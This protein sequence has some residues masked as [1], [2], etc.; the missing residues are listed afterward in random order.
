MNVKNISI[1]INNLPDERKKR[2]RQNLRNKVRQIKPFVDEI[3]ILYTSLSW[4]T[5]RK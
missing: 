5:K 1:K 3:K 4:F 2:I